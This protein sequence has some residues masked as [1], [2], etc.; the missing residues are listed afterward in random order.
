M[1]PW[2]AEGDLLDCREPEPLSGMANSRVGWHSDDEPLF[3][4]VLV[5]QNLIV[6]VSFGSP[7]SSSDGFGKSCPDGEGSL[8][9]ALPW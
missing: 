1:K 8:V 4:R 2:C 5:V 9:L 6:S 3:W 7:S